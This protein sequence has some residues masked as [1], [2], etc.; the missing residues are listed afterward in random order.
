MNKCNKS[1]ETQC[2]EYEKKVQ[3]MRDNAHYHTSQV[4]K[5]TETKKQLRKEELQSSTER[6]LLKAMQDIGLSPEAQYN[7]ELMIVDFAFPKLK[8]AIEIDGEYHRAEPQ[9]DKDKRRD[10]VLAD[11]GWIIWR[12]DAGEVYSNPKRIAIKILKRLATH[13]D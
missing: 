10:F 6:R 8:I 3:A 9:R 5:N 7:I 12:F 13:F 1:F 11:K 2:N 4:F